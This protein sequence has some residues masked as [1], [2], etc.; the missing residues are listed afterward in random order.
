LGTL[1]AHWLGYGVLPAV[2]VGSLLASHTLLG[3]SIVAKLGVK[4][5]EPIVVTF[6]AR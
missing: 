1:V 3:S 6:G 2:V 5:L 4:H